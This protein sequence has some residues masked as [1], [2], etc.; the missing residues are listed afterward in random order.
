MSVYTSGDFVAFHSNVNLDPYLG[1]C[2]VCG[3]KVGK[4]S[5]LVRF[6]LNG[7][8]NINAAGD[9]SYLFAVGS[10]CANKFDAEVLFKND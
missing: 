4:N 1:N 10:E 9:S 8:I 2:V 3:R 7:N 5:T 6:D